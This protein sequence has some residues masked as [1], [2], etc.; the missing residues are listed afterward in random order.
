[1]VEKEVETNSFDKEVN[2]I[3]EVFS[4][5]LRLLKGSEEAEG[6]RDRLYVEE[7]RRSWGYLG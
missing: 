1:M 3:L 2:V 4:K 7:S 5:T 6:A